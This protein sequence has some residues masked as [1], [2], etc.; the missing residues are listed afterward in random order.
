LLV[1]DFAVSVG[2]R[3]DHLDRFRAEVVDY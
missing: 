1:P 3:N 2:E